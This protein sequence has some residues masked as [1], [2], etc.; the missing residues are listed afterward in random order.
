MS[1]DIHVKLRCLLPLKASISRNLDP[2]N[3]RARESLRV[4][5]N[6]NPKPEAKPW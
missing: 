5:L 4:L 3:R 1:V 2:R 6:P